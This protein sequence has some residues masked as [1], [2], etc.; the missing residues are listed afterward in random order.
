[1]VSR[2]VNIRLNASKKIEERL[3]FRA[4]TE[5]Q[6]YLEGLAK[7]FVEPLV[8]LRINYLR[9]SKPNLRE[10]REYNSVESIRKREAEKW[11]A[12]LGYSVLKTKRKRL[13]LGERKVG[14]AKPPSEAPLLPYD[15]DIEQVEVIY[16]E[17]F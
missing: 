5:R 17:Q 16:L 4:Q 15:M 2:D 10:H 14:Q 3:C 11:E 7:P 1:M 8:K 6:K 9:I 12:K 13:D